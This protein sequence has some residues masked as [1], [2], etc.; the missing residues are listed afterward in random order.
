MS[1]T[2]GRSTTAAVIP[3]LVTTAEDR[4]RPI[5]CFQSLLV[6]GET[7]RWHRS[8]VDAG[9]PHVFLKGAGFDNW[10]ARDRASSDV[11]VLV[12]R[13]E[14]RRLGRLLRAEGFVRTVTEPAATT[15]MPRR[16]ASR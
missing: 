15:W 13:A 3:M 5:D 7:F 9:V 6:E 14:L 4:P 1:R 2:A 8:L 16:K 10:L 12:P 11:D